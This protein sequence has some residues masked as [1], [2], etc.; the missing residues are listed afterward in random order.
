MNL[1]SFVTFGRLLQYLRL[2]ERMT[3]RELALATGYSREQITKLENDQRLPQVA[4][5]EALFVPALHLENQPEVVKRLLALASMVDETPA[6]AS[7]TSHNLP[8]HKTNLPDALTSFIGREH[9]ITEIKHLL[10]RTRL[11]TLTGTGGI[12]KTRLALKVG[13]ELL[14]SYPDGVY[15]IEL[16]SVTNPGHIPNALAQALQLLPG[17]EKTIDAALTDYL[18]DK[19]LLLIL[20]NC[21][22]LLVA[23][24]RLA[25]NLLR[26]SPNLRILATSRETLGILSAQ[27]WR[28]PSLALPAESDPIVELAE[29]PEAM[30]LFVE[31]ALF[32]KPDFALTP[33]NTKTI[34]TICRRL[35]C[36]PL[37]IELAATRVRVLSPDQIAE[38][39][40]YRFELLTQGNITVLPRH[41]T[42]RAAIDWSYDLL[43]EPERALLRRL[44][45]FIGGWTLE[46]AE[47][48]FTT[49]DT[50]DLLTQ[51]VDKSLIIVS[52]HYQETRFH[53]LET[54]R[55][56]VLEKLS[57][58]DDSR[59]IYQLHLDYYIAFAEKASPA[60]RTSQQKIWYDRLEIEHDNLRAALQWAIRNDN[61]F[62]GCKL[63]AALS[64]FW[65]WRGY[66]SEGAEWAKAILALADE[67]HKTADKPLWAKTLIGAIDI[68]G[69]SG[70][71]SRFEEWLG[72]LSTL[73]DELQDNV[74]LAW[75]KT[76]TSIQL[77]DYSE[78]M[79]ALEE[80]VILARLGGDL[81][82]MADALYMMGD[83]ARGTGEDEKAYNYYSESAAVFR[84][85]GDWD[86]LANQLGNLGRLAFYRGDDAQA[87][88]AFEE[89]IQ[90]HRTLGNRLGKADWLLQLAT[91]ALYQQDYSHA[92]AALIECLPIYQS[93]G[94]M[95]AVADVLALAAR[96]VEAKGQPET[97]AQLLGAADSLLEKFSIIHQ[98]IDPRSAQ[99]FSRHV[100][101]IKARLSSEDFSAAWRTGRSLTIDQ[102]VKFVLALR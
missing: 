79:T 10:A 9:E 7:S 97:A 15:F 64:H 52:D 14:S 58:E 65:F 67:S 46:G 62:A 75:V 1:N 36:I 95:E 69:R 32:V 76:M 89:S 43:S 39:L 49:Q 13:E 73:A 102:M 12:G 38:R 42:L 96:L 85:L 72:E 3:Q 91:V 93:I 70:D 35:D 100:E 71:F 87:R 16:A 40:A 21:E 98:V 51:L 84:Q 55:E 78:A 60:L 63:I 77:P 41:Q 92:Q 54:I 22:H 25:E 27:S 99:E 11:L 34:A 44:V 17:N 24:A 88:A 82:L 30:Q 33:A 23:C 48:V 8:S 74:L 83:R 80:A 68:I 2:K 6:P 20:D 31:R 53:M 61:V 5:I 81:W 26:A 19:H 47:A 90:I 66:W 56:Y 59:H 29:A 50:L 37:A 45:P 28:V 94:N 4:V 101:V 18:R 86:S 57:H